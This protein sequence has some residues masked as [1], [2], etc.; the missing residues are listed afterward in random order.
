MRQV[1]LV[2]G[3]FGALG[4]AIVAEFATR[5]YRVA[6]VDAAPVPAD[7]TCDAAIGGV[8]LTSADAVAASY[9]EIAKRLGAIDALVNVAGGFVWEPLEHGTV[10]SW[11]RMYRTNLLTAAVSSRTALPYLLRRGGAIVNVGAAAAARP[12]GGFAPYAASKAGVAALTESLADE[13]RSRGVRVNAILPTIIDTPANRQEMPDA[14][15]EHWV[16]PAAAAKVV[17]F[18]VSGEAGAIT[19]AS[20]PLSLAG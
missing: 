7:L 19:G 8:D 18:L 12:A 17:A 5:G 10:E 3:A 2:A 9:A 4:R 13:L 16:R 14:D 15:R 11:D 1:V 6:A 20:I